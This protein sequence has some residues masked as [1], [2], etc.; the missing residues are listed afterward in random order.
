MVDQEL[1]ALLVGALYGELE[2]AD[3]ARLAAH[4]E[5]HPTDRS[6]LDDLRSTR[7]ALVDARFFELWFD[8]PPAVSARLVQEAA[9]RAPRTAASGDGWFMRFVRSL[10]MHP[11]MAAAAMLV[12]VVGVAGTLYMK[13][14]ADLAEPSSSVAMARDEVAP[15]PPA[16]AAAGSG[17]PASP[18]ASTTAPPG[19]ENGIRAELADG[20]E[21]DRSVQVAKT[22]AT[23]ED[24][25]AKRPVGIVVGHRE[26]APKDLDDKNAEIAT[27]DAVASSSGPD[28]KQGFAKSPAP[29]AQA[30]V[31]PPPPPPATAAIG[32]A[33][34]GGAASANTKEQPAD[35]WARD[36]HARV[37]TLVQNGRCQDAAPL[38]AEIKARAPAYYSEH[39]STDRSI[40][41]CMA[42]IARAVEKQ[43][44]ERSK[45]DAA[46]AAKATDS[47]R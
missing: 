35:A 2:P 23:S 16:A 28:F 10:A 27:G 30:P 21:V 34:G 17:S 5:S 31:E 37:A 22:K 40:K 3:E 15:A 39:V 4:L 26:A 25:P 11:A 1:D 41:S 46:K 42:Y 9:R 38:A 24:M 13:K 45:A 47:K 29:V 18:V 43:D 14:G 44:A 7:K 32:A 36:Q 8:P 33:G 20:K 19:T 6:A 12:V